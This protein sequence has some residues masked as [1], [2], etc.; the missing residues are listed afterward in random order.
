MTGV[1]TCALPILKAGVAVACLTRYQDL[2]D[3]QGLK[4]HGIYYYVPGMLRHFDT[5][6]VVALAAPRAL[7]CMNGG[8]DHGS[9]TTG[10]RK[11]EA[12]AAPAWKLYGRPAEFRSEVFPGIGHEYTQVMWKQMLEWMDAHLQPRP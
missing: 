11:I 10:I 3:A 9:P 8:E 5:E 12:A 4:H 6:A 7:L 1:Q 2:I